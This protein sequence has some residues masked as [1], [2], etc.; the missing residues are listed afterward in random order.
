MLS[1]VYQDDNRSNNTAIDFFYYHSRSIPNVKNSN[2]LIGLSR[3]P[4]ITHNESTYLPSLEVTS[5]ADIPEGMLGDVIPT[6]KYAIFKYTG[7]HAP[8]QITINTLSDIYSH[9]LEWLS[10]SSYTLADNFHFESIDNKIATNNYCEA[11]IY[12]PIK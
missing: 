8:S 12:I 9:I 6:H 5:L 1:E 4:H 2:I 7:L 3:Y 10:V 11:E